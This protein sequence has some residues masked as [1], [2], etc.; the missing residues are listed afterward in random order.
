MSHFGVYVCLSSGSE[1]DWRTAV[2]GAL[3]PYR[4]DD[5]TGLGEWDYWNSSGQFLVRP[6]Y[7]DDPLIVPSSQWPADPLRCDGGPKKVLD[8][9]GMRTAARD[10]AYQ[11]WAAWREAVSRH[12]PARSIEECESRAEYEAQPLVAE[13]TARRDDE[14]DVLALLRATELAYLGD[15]EQRFIDMAVQE[16]LLTYALVTV[17]GQWFDVEQTPDFTALLWP[18]LDGLPDDTFIIELDCHS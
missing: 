18:Y 15:D 3:A 9:A 6:E 16:A 17:D 2:G 12:P 14:D 5:E 4:I 11:V 7:V 10:R 8:L 1:A 13:I